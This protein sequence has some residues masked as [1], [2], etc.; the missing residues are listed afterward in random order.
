MARLPTRGIAPG[1]E[2]LFLGA[3]APRHFA[4][5]FFGGHAQPL[6]EDQP[7]LPAVL[8]PLLVR[9]PLQPELD[10][11]VDEFRILDP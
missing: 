10:Q 11:P 9:V 5:Q 8:I 7:I 6:Y 2:D 1:S 4:S 3:V